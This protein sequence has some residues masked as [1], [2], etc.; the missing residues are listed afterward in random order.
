MEANIKEET[1][2]KRVNYL[3]KLDLSRLD[4]GEVKNKKTQYHAELRDL[5]RRLNEFTRQ[6]N[7]VE[8]DYVQEHEKDKVYDMYSRLTDALGGDSEKA[9]SVINAMID[10]SLKRSEQQETN[11]PEE[12]QNYV[13]K[14]SGND[15]P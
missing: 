5:H 11:K 7:T 10:Q 12:S 15:L 13:N 8:E 1:L 4:L 2:E 14:E 3:L 9:R 6:L